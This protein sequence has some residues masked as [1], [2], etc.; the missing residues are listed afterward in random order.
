[1]SAPLG[2]T[3]FHLQ[4]RSAGVALSETI[5]QPS[6]TM[7]SPRREIG[8]IQPVILPFA[9]YVLDSLKNTSRLSTVQSRRKRTSN[10]NFLYLQKRDIRI[11]RICIGSF[12]TFFFVYLSCQSWRKNFRIVN[13]LLSLSRNSVFRLFFR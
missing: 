1:M 4:F 9:R 3:I 13:I 7:R 8:I 2:P 12:E 6:G 10:W 5:Y 11:S